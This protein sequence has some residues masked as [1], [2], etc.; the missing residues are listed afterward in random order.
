MPSGEHLRFPAT[1]IEDELRQAVDRHVLAEDILSALLQRRAQMHT[2]DFMQAW[3]QLLAFRGE[4]VQI[5]STDER[6]I[7][8]RLVGLWPDGSLKLRAETGE[9]IQVNVGEVS[10]RPAS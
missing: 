7:E 6:P 10:L 1:C 8:G 2:D 3:E 4:N 5:R 9:D